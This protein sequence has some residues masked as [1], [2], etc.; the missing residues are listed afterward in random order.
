M[1]YELLK[2]PQAANQIEKLF[3]VNCSLIKILSK[4]TGS[5]V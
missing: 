3:N 5:C 4:P 1:K 2:S